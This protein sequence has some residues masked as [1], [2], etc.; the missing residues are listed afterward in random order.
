MH[1]SISHGLLTKHM[2]PEKVLG[3]FNSLHMISARS[4]VWP[5][6]RPIFLLRPTNNER[7]RK[8]EKV[9][10]NSKACLPETLSGVGLGR[11]VREV[12][13]HPDDHKFDSQRWQ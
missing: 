6:A 3:L 12:R 10:T 5:D 1:T 9:I 11:V 2:H 4:V 7:K 8:S 13:Q